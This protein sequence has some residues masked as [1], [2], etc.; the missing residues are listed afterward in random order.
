[1]HWYDK[2]GEPQHFTP[3]KKGGLRPTTL[4]DARKYGWVPS[5]TSVLDILAKPGLEAWKV[6]KAIESSRLIP[7]QVDEHNEEHAKRVL[8]HSRKES[9]EAAERGNII[10]NMLEV[11]F[12]TGEAPHNQDHK[13]MFE[14]VRAVLQINCGEQDWT[15]EKSFNAIDYGGK[16]DLSSKEW[17]IDFK[18]KEFDADHKKLEYESMAYQLVAYDVGLNTSYATD[19]REHKRRIANVFISSTNPGLVVFHEWS[20]ED[21]KRYWTIFESSLEVWKNIKKY[22]PENHDERN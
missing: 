16:I 19:H 4:R 2:D 15:P 7:K 13:E 21:R 3:S 17:V 5:V 20:D 12:T 8:A 6:N 10:H 14:S 18:T 22:W 9:E 1:M 11:A